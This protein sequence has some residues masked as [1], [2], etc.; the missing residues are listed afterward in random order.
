MLCTI[1]ARE[2]A[3]TGAFDS[4]LLIFAL[5]EGLVSRIALDFRGL[6]PC[7]VNAVDF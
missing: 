6:I 1:L 5:S 2:V 4:N 7:R 3:A